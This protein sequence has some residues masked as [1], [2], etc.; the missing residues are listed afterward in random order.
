MLRLLILAPLT[1]ANVKDISFDYGTL[2]PNFE[3]SPGEVKQSYTLHV[4]TCDPGT[5]LKP[6]TLNVYADESDAIT[7]KDDRNLEELGYGPQY[8]LLLDKNLGITDEGFHGTEFTITAKLP[9]G[10]VQVYE[11]NIGPCHRENTDPAQQ[12]VNCGPMPDES[13]YAPATTPAPPLECNIEHAQL[14]GNECKCMLGYVGSI[15]LEGRLF[16]GSCKSIYIGK[17]PCTGETP[18]V[19]GRCPTCAEADAIMLDLEQSCSIPLSITLDNIIWHSQHGSHGMIHPD[20]RRALCISPICRYRI[21]LA[22]NAF[23]L[24][25]TLAGKNIF[26]ETHFRDETYSLHTFKRVIFVLHKTKEDC[27][28]VRSAT[29]VAASTMLRMKLLVTGVDVRSDAT[30]RAAEVAYRTAF[31]RV[32]NWPKRRMDVRIEPELCLVD[33]V[34]QHNNCGYG[35]CVPHWYA[36]GSQGGT[37]QNGETSW[38]SAV[39]NIITG[40]GENTSVDLNSRNADYGYR[41][42]CNECFY[43]AIEAGVKTCKREKICTLKDYCNPNPCGENGKCRPCPECAQRGEEPFTCECP[44]FFSGPRCEIFECPDGFEELAHTE[45]EKTR[46]CVPRNVKNPCRVVK[47]LHGGACVALDDAGNKAQ[48]PETAT[49]WKCVCRNPFVGERCESYNCMEGTHPTDA[50]CV[51]DTATTTI[52]PEE[53]GVLQNEGCKPTPA[54][55][56][57]ADV[58]YSGPC[59]TGSISDQM[60]G[61]GI[62]PCQNNGY[63]ETD[64]SKMCGFRCICNGGFTGSRCESKIASDICS[65]VKCEGLSKCIP[66][67]KSIK[68][69]ICECNEWCKEQEAISRRLTATLAGIEEPLDPFKTG[70]NQ[71]DVH[72][73][74]H[75]LS[76]DS[77][78]EYEEAKLS[79]EAEMDRLKEN[80]QGW[81]DGRWLEEAPEE[82]Q[83]AWEDGAALPATR[84]LPKEELPE[85]NQ[86]MVWQYGD[87]QRAEVVLTLKCPR[88]DPSKCQDMALILESMHQRHNWRALEHVVRY[89]CIPS[90]VNASSEVTEEVLVSNCPTLPVQ[91]EAWRKTYIGCHFSECNLGPEDEIA[92]IISK[93]GAESVDNIYKKSIC[94]IPMCRSLIMEYYGLFKDCRNSAPGEMGKQSRKAKALY[95]FVKSCSNPDPASTIAV[96]RQQIKIVGV[97]DELSNTELCAVEDYVKQD[98]VAN[99]VGLTEQ[100]DIDN[101]LFVFTRPALKRHNT[102]NARFT[103]PMGEFEPT[104]LPEKIGQLDPSCTGLCVMTTQPGPNPD[105][106]MDPSAHIYVTFNEP[107]I[108]GNCWGTGDDNCHVLLE[109]EGTGSGTEIYETYN[110]LEDEMYNLNRLDDN[111]F[112]SGETMFLR[113]WY[114]LK[115][116][117]KYKVTIAPGIV[118]PV[119]NLVPS[120]VEPIVYTFETGPPQGSIVYLSIS[121]GC[122]DVSDCKYCS[123]KLRDYATSPETTLVQP[124]SEFIDNFRKKKKEETGFLVTQRRLSAFNETARPDNLQGGLIRENFQLDMEKA[125]QYRRLKEKNFNATLFYMAENLP[126]TADGSSKRRLQAAPAEPAPAAGAVDKTNGGLTAPAGA[127]GFPEV[128]IRVSNDVVCVLRKTWIFWNILC[129]V[130]FL[131]AILAI[132]CAGRSISWWVQDAFSSYTG[133]FKNEMVDP[134]NPDRKLV[135]WKSVV[136]ENSMSFSRIM[137][138]PAI[139]WPIIMILT[140]I[141]LWVF[142]FFFCSSSSNSSAN[143]M[144]CGATASTISAIVFALLAMISAAWVS[145]AH[146]PFYPFRNRFKNSEDPWHSVSWLDAP[147][148]GEPGPRPGPGLTQKD[149]T[150]EGKPLSPPDAHADGSMHEQRDSGLQEMMLKGVEYHES[151][152]EITFTIPK[153]KASSR[154]Q[155]DRLN[156]P[157]RSASHSAAWTFF[158]GVAAV[159][160]GL[161]CLP[162]NALHICP[163]FF[164]SIFLIALIALI[165]TLLVRFCMYALTKK[166]C[167]FW[168]AAKTA[169]AHEYL[170]VQNDDRG[171]RYS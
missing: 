1:R 4:A 171:T 110:D 46:S 62:S 107:I 81:L 105:A 24:C 127:A 80:E 18:F 141:L 88:D 20:L 83:S 90:H 76:F 126:L 77:D 131:L 158:L 82:V 134:K 75:L 106:K 57:G 100:S 87:D 72:D 116:F 121:L 146:V 93:L 54:Q 94:K 120:F 91:Q 41:C 97:L 48:H 115:P 133:Y 117:S 124:I 152:K 112:I 170:Q 150:P 33:P 154:F 96:I 102:L 144:I 74:R 130:C 13:P 108:P 113:P 165:V 111:I 98:L 56:G 125:M 119:S 3:P 29:N 14:I 22:Q 89:S 161:I 149:S 123:N 153:P 63:C 44:P 59:E 35:S 60:G 156:D 78:R 145:P 55:G 28:T 47:C 129:F 164:F 64:S 85:H 9:N 142:G 34:C 160:I 138:G 42:L 32:L 37:S 40:P 65:R 86:C 53:P 30:M 26:S 167:Q 36:H 109:V 7:I 15:K 73:F 50:G 11:I 151:D 70:M 118:E 38:W 68:G 137:R 104:R 79:H 140:V 166:H 52:P 136:T 163:E 49:A 6:L 43:E 155:P 157:Y 12:C 143:G 71:E 66:T 162:M 8:T 114:T 51:P 5:H 101:R 31:S 23:A 45:G 27:H 139:W 19:C 10:E 122:T 95:N 17:W 67:D 99:R 169:Q 128:E 69:Y 159:I 39:T 25:Q 148:A 58:K 2:D 84:P 21:E 16:I 103:E 168:D 132:F 61:D 147:K 92:V 135:Y